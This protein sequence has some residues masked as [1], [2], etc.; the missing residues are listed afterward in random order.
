MLIALPARGIP[1][2]RP[3]AERV[4]THIRCRLI[5]EMHAEAT[6]LALGRAR[7]A[8]GRLGG[9]RCA[10]GRR[11][12]GPGPPTD[13]DEPR[14]AHTPPLIIETRAGGAVLTTDGS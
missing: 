12:G 1:P 9:A 8:V 6:E 13:R 11:A 10:A 4:A 7:A 3:A 2:R 14:R 5:T